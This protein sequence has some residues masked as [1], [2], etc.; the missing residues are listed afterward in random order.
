MIYKCQICGTEIE[1][2][3]DKTNALSLKLKKHLQSEHSMTLEQ[4]CIDVFYGGKHP[5][6]ACG[7]GEPLKFKSKNWVKTHGFGKYSSCTHVTHSIKSIE[8][9]KQT[10]EDNK[11]KHSIQFINDK[12]GGIDNIKKALEEFK[13]KI[14]S[15][16]DIA[17]KLNIDKR[18]LKSIWVRHNLITYEEIN[19]LVQYTQ[20]HIGTL[21]RID[22]LSNKDEIL[23]NLYTIITTNPQKYTVKSLIREYNRLN[24][25]PI[26]NKLNHKRLLSI[27]AERYG[28]SV[29]ENIQYGYH[30][31]EE[32]QFLQV[33]QFYFGVNHVKC[34]FKQEYKNEN[35]ETCTYIYD[36]IIKN[37]VVIEYDG[38]GYY[39]QGEEKQKRDKNKENF[40]I[41]QGYKFLR[42]SRIDSKDPNT[43]NLIFK[44]LSL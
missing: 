33:L 12:C 40:I 1:Y 27:L 6:C 39:H 31:K 34:G 29:Y 21:K 10:W 41:Q 28:D 38:D 30:S 24:E 14:V 8:K 42:L 44:L 13:L 25:I 16:T 36:F 20:F 35:N 26:S 9:G 2:A 22:C 37:K 3:D 11:V 4:Y 23:H 17:K 18:T 43:I 5:V 19:E 15:L 7:C 32:I